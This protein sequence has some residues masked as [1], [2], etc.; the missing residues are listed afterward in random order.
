M[1]TYPMDTIPMDAYPMDVEQPWVSFGSLPPFDLLNDTAKKDPCPLSC[2]NPFRLTH[3]QLPSPPLQHCQRTAA[4]TSFP[5]KN[6]F[7]HPQ[8]NSHTLLTT[9]APPPQHRQPCQRMAA[10]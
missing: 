1:D 7:P 9:P 4:L 10:T 3:T 6:D 2:K 5:N 8:T